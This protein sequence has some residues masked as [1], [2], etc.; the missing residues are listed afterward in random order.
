MESR[1]ELRKEVLMP[2]HTVEKVI[3]YFTYIHKSKYQYLNIEILCYKQKYRFENV[4]E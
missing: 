2:W 3:T 1:P 4:L